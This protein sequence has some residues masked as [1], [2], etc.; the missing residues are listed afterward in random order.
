VLRDLEVSAH[1][2]FEIGIDTARNRQRSRGF[3]LSPLGLDVGDVGA[4]DPQV[5]DDLGQFT[6]S[7]I[8][9]PPT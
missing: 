2:Y 1:E 5:V 3:P 4:E 6:L 8:F 9:H 7:S